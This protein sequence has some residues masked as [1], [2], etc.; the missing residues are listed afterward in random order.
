MSDQISESASGGGGMQANKSHLP[1]RAECTTRKVTS[2]SPVQRGRLETTLRV[3]RFCRRL[4]QSRKWSL[5]WRGLE[6]MAPSRLQETGHTGTQNNPLRTRITQP[7]IHPAACSLGH[8]VEA[9]GLDLSEA[10]L[11]TWPPGP[12]AHPNPKAKFTGQAVTKPAA[13]F[14]RGPL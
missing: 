10:I 11:T 4:T 6:R 8:L 12:L 3:L 2:S 14:P 13:G 7:L 9:W 1:S 5:G